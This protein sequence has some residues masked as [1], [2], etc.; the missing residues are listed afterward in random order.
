VGPHGVEGGGWGGP[1]GSCSP[2]VS[3]QAW[4]TFGGFRKK[5]GGVPW[6]LIL[7]WLASKEGV[8]GSHGGGEG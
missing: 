7:D 5:G 6:G 8:E 2:V 4:M 3:K 1:T